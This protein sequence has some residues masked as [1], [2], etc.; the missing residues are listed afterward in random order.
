MSGRIDFSGIERQLGEIVR[1]IDR[2]FQDLEERERHEENVEKQNKLIKEQISLVKWTRILAIFTVI[3]ASGTIIM[4]Y[5]S[6]YANSLQEQKDTTVLF[7]GTAQNIGDNSMAVPLLNQ[8]STSN[9]AV[10]ECINIEI[11]E[12]Y[13]YPPRVDYLPV[14][15]FSPVNVS[16][17]GQ[18]TNINITTFPNGTSPGLLKKEF[19][20]NYLLVDSDKPTNLEIYYAPPYP[21]KI[22]DH[23]III[24]IIPPLRFDTSK[25][26]KIN[27]SYHPANN[28][29]NKKIINFGIFF[30]EGYNQPTTLYDGKSDNFNAGSQKMVAWIRNAS[31]LNDS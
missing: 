14:E 9:R 19:Y 18:Y 31:K 26:A 13:F 29:K 3:M 17:C 30:G 20:Y 27:I 4:A 21:Q 1:K 11:T 7:P 22:N 10:I 23:S 2:P 24:S 8:Y 28:P 15:I 5:L 6:I 16:S 25:I 12:L